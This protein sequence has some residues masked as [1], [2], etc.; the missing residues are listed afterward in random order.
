MPGELHFVFDT[1]AII[2][3]ALL[4][5]SVTRRAYERAIGQGKL[6]ASVETIEEVSEV[7]GRPD[8]G[9]YVTED[10]R[11]EFLAVFMQET[12]LVSVRE[13]VDECRDPDDNKILELAVSGHAVC[14]VSG[15]KDLLVLNP[16]R[17]I[18]ILTPAEFL[19]MDWN[20]SRD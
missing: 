14:I 3:A 8:F 2:S 13:R 18:V 19:N 11:L 10:E 15:D 9:R 20:A 6:I 17:G 4:K 7:L 1:N 16:F 5:Q 12:K